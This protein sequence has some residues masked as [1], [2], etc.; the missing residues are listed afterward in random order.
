MSLFGDT[1]EAAVTCAHGRTSVERCP[2][3]LS[4]ERRLLDALDAP[5]AW[6][7][8]DHT[9]EERA[10]A[11]TVAH[12]SGSPYRRMVLAAH[13]DHQD[14]LTDDDVARIVGHPD[15]PPPRAA[16]RRGE[17]ARDG[18][19]EKLYDDDGKRVTRPTR[20]GHPAQVW[21]LTNEARRL[22]Y[23]GEVVL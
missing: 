22:I 4:D 9:P 5:L 21:R 18:W 6:L 8:R 19:L 12:I 15:M 11:L 16:S 10:A 20:T 17:L 2:S 23:T 14:G 1:P 7:R 13:Y 3:C